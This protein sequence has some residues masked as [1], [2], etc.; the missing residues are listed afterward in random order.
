MCFKLGS[1]KLT[2][3]RVENCSTLL[4]SLLTR[5]SRTWLYTPSKCFP[6]VTLPYLWDDP[7]LPLT[8]SATNS[9]SILNGSRVHCSQ[10]IVHTNRFDFV[11]RVATEP[12]TKMLCL[13][14]VFTLFLSFIFIFN[15]SPPPPPNSR[16]RER[17]DFFFL[18]LV[19]AYPTHYTDWVVIL[20]V[21]HI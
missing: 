13:F 12:A 18:N 6:R 2:R 20:S 17:E 10:F 19:L 16:E 8:L 1:C 7:N 11:N 9:P 5:H 21:S 4:S 15:P 3:R 14:S